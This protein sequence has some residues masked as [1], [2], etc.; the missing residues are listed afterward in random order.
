MKWIA[1]I[2]ASLGFFLLLYLVLHHDMATLWEQWLAIGATGY[3]LLVLIHT[4]P[5]ALS[6]LAWQ[7]W[8]QTWNK[9]GETPYPFSVFLLARWIRESAKLLLP[10]AQIGGDVIGMRV[11]TLHG[12]KTKEAIAMTTAD[13]TLEVLAQLAFTAVGVALLSLLVSAEQ[14][15]VF[16]LGLIGAGLVIVAFVAAQRWGLLHLI[17]KAIGFIAKPLLGSEK[18]LLGL[19]DSLLGY[20]R[21]K[22]AV[23]RSFML[24]FAAWLAGAVEVWAIFWLIGHPI[25]LLEA[26]LIE[27]LV[28]AIKSVA[29]I[30]PAALGVQEGAFI[31]VASTL[32]AS[33]TPA[34]ALLASLV[35]R[36]RHL[37]M[38]LPA[39]LWWHVYELRALNRRGTLERSQPK[40]TQP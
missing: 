23:I 32:L 13:I 30:I 7:S 40:E 5:I 16:V 28:Q 21:N 27:A 10:L 37:L 15:Y 8:G 6:A 24:H 31:L 18:N 26:M 12:M 14:A 9:A 4:L 33:T 38:G 25:T 36:G 2:A 34:L 1:L 17:D 3:G 35:R 11:M 29:F 19:H 22:G 39:L 20:Y